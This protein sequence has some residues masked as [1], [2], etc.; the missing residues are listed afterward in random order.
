MT[1]AGRASVPGRSVGPFAL[2]SAASGPNAGRLA[3]PWPLCV[4][5]RAPVEPAAPRAPALQALTLTVSEVTV[6]ETKESLLT[7]WSNVCKFAQ[8]SWG[9]GT[10]WGHVARSGIS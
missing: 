2:S 9:G 3:G 7:L 6:S 4:V 10:I 5:N 8:A 1:E